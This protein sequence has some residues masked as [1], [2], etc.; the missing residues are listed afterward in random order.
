VTPVVERADGALPRWL[1]EKRKDPQDRWVHHVDELLP[2]GFEAYLRLFHPFL[3][4]GADPATTD[5][6]DHRTWRSLAIEAGVEFNGR[7]TWR[8]LEPVLPIE[9]TG[10][11]FQVGHGNLDPAVR[12]RLFSLLRANTAPQA[13]YF[14]YGLSAILSD[15]H[16]AALFEAPLNSADDVWPIAGSEGFAAETPELV[17]PEDRS[18]AICTDYDLTSTYIGSDRNLAGVLMDD[19]QLEILEVTMDTRVD[20]AADEQSP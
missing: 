17:W 11:R 1:E 4:W 7:L 15:R 5:V 16:R 6:G 13:A 2:D 10:R 12:A 19:S 20:N 18:W 14:F 9:D 8:Q 3:P